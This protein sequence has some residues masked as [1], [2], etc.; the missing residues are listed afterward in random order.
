MTTNYKETD[1]V[2]A[3][4]QGDHWAFSV[5]MDT[6]KNLVFSLALKMLKEK[7]E[8]EEVAQDSFIKAFNGI[9]NFKGDSKLS[10]WLYKIVY[11]ACLDRI[12]KKKSSYGT[13]SLEDR[14]DISDHDALDA[15]KIMEDKDLKREVKRCFDKIDEEDAFLLT[16][17]YFEEQSLEEIG[18]LLDITTNNAKVRLYRARKKMA[19]VF[20]E[21]LESELIESYERKRK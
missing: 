13:I 18:K 6:Y 16:L 9:E 19:S 12:K 11:Y 4:K 20:K 8:A 2:E 15:S 14:Y 21:H 7:E 17:F 10:T 5:F 1:L 3:I